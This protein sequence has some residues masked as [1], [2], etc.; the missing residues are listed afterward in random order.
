MASCSPSVPQSSDGNGESFGTENSESEKE[1][2]TSEEEN[3]GDLGE[4]ELP[5]VPKK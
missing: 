5:F 3:S 2:T 4:N 1:E